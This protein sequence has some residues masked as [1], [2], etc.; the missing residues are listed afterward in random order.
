MPEQHEKIYTA[1]TEQTVRLDMFMGI[2][3]QDREDRKR[4]EDKLFTKVNAVD[5]AL[6]SKADK[7][8][9]N[10]ALEKKVSKGGVTIVVSIIGA[11]F[12]I[13]GFLNAVLL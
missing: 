6:E 13:L 12:L 7:K 5:K 10:E 3:E 1:I 11:I 9:V 8:E 4:A 2:V